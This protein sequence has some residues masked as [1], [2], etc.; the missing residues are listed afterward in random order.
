MVG[1]H[2]IP[3]GS[4]YL[5][6]RLP[7]APESSLLNPDLPVAASADRCVVPAGGQ[8]LAY[9]LLSPV[10]RKAYLDWQA[11]GRRTDVM[12]GLVL[13][14]CAGLERRILVD[15]NDDP[16]VHQELPALTA[17]VRRLRARYG[18]DAA[19]LGNALDHL[20]DLLGLLTAPRDA[21][22]A[23]PDRE[24][25][26]GVRIALARF[27]VSST[28]MPAAWARAWIRH[29]PSLTPRRSENDCP[30]EFERLFTVRYGER[31]GR[32]I[33]VPGDG[34]GIRLSYRPSNPGL[35][36]TLVWRADLPDLLS[37]PR[38]IRALSAL[39]DE[40][41]ASLDP[42]RRWLA[43]FP[44][45]Q[46]SLA[47]VPLLPAG[48]VD[49]RHGR[50]GA[51][52]VWAERRLDGQPRAL[53]DA[54][55]FWDFWSAADPERMATDEAAALL[56]VLAK[57]GLGV[58]PDVRFG[59][60]PLVPGPAVLFR[61][62]RPAADRPGPRFAA[63]AAIVRCAAVV[64]SAAGPV[65]PRGPAGTA[66]LTTVADLVAA[67]CLEPGEDLRLAARLGWLLT[68]WVDVDRLGRQTTTMTSAER[69]IAG[70]YLVTVAVTADPVIGPA[71]V[72]ALTRL[73]RILGL[74]VDLVFQRLHDWSTAGAPVLPQLAG[75][76]V[77]R[78]PGRRHDPDAGAEGPDEPVVVQSGGHEP[79][80]YPLPW[81]ASTGLRLDRSL[82][83]KKVAD[84]GT[85]AAL[86]GVI[87]DDEEVADP[88]EP[89]SAIAGLDRAHGALLHALGERG[90]WTRAEFESLAAAHGVLP[91]G[92]L[93]A[94]NEAAID[95]TGAPIVEGEDTLTLANDV[96]LELLA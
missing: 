34:T 40:V 78:V 70:H 3:G 11:G 53:I 77:A 37:E 20:L 91:D 5:G 21:P 1:G 18:D 94:L 48:L 7:G 35:A 36:A 59:A 2:I 67:L 74:Q 39:R 10:A 42:Y 62:G 76:D 30:A 15:G 69:E 44:Q 46:G 31:H 32:G 85:A 71:T 43:R 58:E 84:S 27:A 49:A 33:V 60:P 75:A 4:I 72:T 38:R 86:L 29:H 88:A 9:Q 28:P 83:R 52:R 95:A 16:V 19:A 45:G 93:D 68:T 61:L 47:A 24:T 73:Y 57:L 80:G 17:E 12:P 26:M 23:G 41:A 54:A 96:L 79:S 66:L 92:A 63:A 81:A 13:L 65:D 89:P 90:A 56:G 87:F 25:P 22:T 8:G 6:R 55:E 14:F 50:L 82:I 64:A 51:V